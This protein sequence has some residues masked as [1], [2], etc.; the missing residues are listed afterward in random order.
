[1]TRHEERVFRTG[2][3]KTDLAT[4]RSQLQRLKSDLEQ[5][6]ERNRHSAMIAPLKERIRE[7]EATIGAAE[8]RSARPRATGWTGAI[9]GSVARRADAAPRA[10]APSAERYPPR[11][12]ATGA[13]EDSLDGLTGDEPASDG[14]ADGQDGEAPAAVIGGDNAP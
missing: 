7:L 6:L 13:G 1:M 8:E 14:T 2:K 4:L 9:D 3:P 5:Y 10:G 12:R 11:R